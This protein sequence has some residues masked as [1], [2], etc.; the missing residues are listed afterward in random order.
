MVSL[1]GNKWL[2]ELKIEE[3]KLKKRPLLLSRWMDFKIM[4]H[5]CCQG[6]GKVP[7]ETFF[8]VG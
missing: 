7:F 2:P 4:L 3:K 6:G 1:H 8:Q 5:S